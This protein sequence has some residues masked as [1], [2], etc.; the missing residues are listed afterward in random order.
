MRL[1]VRALTAVVVL[2]APACDLANNASD[3]GTTLTDPEAGTL[4]VPGRKLTEGRFRSLAYASSDQ[5]GGR[6]LT[7]SD[8][9]GESHL[10]ITS[11]VDGTTCDAGPAAKVRALSYE[12]NWTFPELVSCESAPDEQGKRSIRFVDLACGDQLQPLVDA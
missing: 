3:L 4:D 1:L 12:S 10:A 11:F 9:D 8:R 5:S 6:V 7:L 2:G